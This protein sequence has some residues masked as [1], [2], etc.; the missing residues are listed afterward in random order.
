[1]VRPVQFL[2]SAWILLM[3]CSCKDHQLT[4]GPSLDR[5]QIQLRASHGIYYVNDVAFTG[6]LF[7]RLTTGDTISLASYL[8][9]REHGVWSTNYRKGARKAIRYFVEGKKQG[10]YK[11]WWENGNLKLQAHFKNDEFDGL[12]QTW[13][14]DGSLTRQANYVAGHEEGAQKVWYAN[15]KVKSNYVVLMGRRYGLLGTKHC[16]NVSDSIFSNL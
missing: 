11:I 15:G 3:A 16:I 13:S 1:M 2:F 10:E 7:E 9:G 4:E 8:N 14:E 12:M 5:H 6:T